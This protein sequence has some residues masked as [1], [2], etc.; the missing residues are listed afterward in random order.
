ME[1]MKIRKTENLIPTILPLYPNKKVLVKKSIQLRKCLMQS[2]SGFSILQS[3]I[4][5][6]TNKEKEENSSSSF[7]SHGRDT[8]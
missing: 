1:T 6:P 2:W 5:V 4:M 7:L 8:P 3:Q